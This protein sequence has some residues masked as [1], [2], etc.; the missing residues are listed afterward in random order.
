MKSLLVATDFSARSDRALRRA[1]L[2][3]KQHDAR[4]VLLHIIDG[5]QPK[6]MMEA[7][8]TVA[9]QI[10]A[11]LR[12]TV[13]AVDGLAC[14]ARLATGTPYEAIVA[15]A[16]KADADLTVMG[17]H[18]R[19]ALKDMFVGTT[20]ERATRTGHRPVLIASALPKSRYTGVLIATDM[21]D[22]SARS[23]EAA[24][25][26]GLFDGPKVGVV[27][28]FDAPAQSLML[29]SSTTSA[30]LKAYIAAQRAAA[31]EELK[32]F[33]NRLRLRPDF[34]VVELPE[35]SKADLIDHCV[36]RYQSDLVIIGTQGRSAVGRFLLGSV[37]EEVLRGSSVDVLAV[38]NS[39]GAAA[40]GV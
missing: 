22:A 10:L 40:S 39:N 5:D 24:R 11:E 33:L 17:A 15:A 7:E 38:P 25:E 30:D 8:W 3:A 29:S 28:G 26:R 23:I 6:Q 12:E 16:D 14:D 31:E 32:G 19:H 2:L 4:I 27:H 34:T 1:T 21:S 13:Q 18:R 36:R 35:T 20:V 9:G 37:A